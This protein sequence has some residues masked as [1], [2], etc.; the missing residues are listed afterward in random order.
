MSAL[1][2]F[3]SALFQRLRDNAGLAAYQHPSMSAAGVRTYDHVP[4][5]ATTP[6]I[7]IE[8]HT[9]T[10]LQAFRGAVGHDDTAQLGVWD[11]YNGFARILAIIPLIGDALDTPLTVAGFGTVRARIENVTTAPLQGGYRRAVLRI[12]ALNLA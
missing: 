6:Y 4:T 2:P 3:H 8:S 9:E 12:R 11:N 10:A 1:G 7:A 5:T